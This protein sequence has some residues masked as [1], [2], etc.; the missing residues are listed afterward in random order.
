[1]RTRVEITEPDK[2]A[3]F[4]DDAYGSRLRLSRLD[5]PKCG[6]AVLSHIRL[7]AGAF[8]LDEIELLGSFTAAPDPLH[9]VA[10]VWAQRGRI[11]G[12]CGGVE[13]IARPGE[14]TLLAQPDLPFDAG[15]E[16]VALTTVLLDPAL[17]ASVATGM[18]PAQAPQQIRFSMFEPVDDPARRLWQHTVRYIRDSVL[19][20]DALASPL[21]LGH[22]ARMLAAATLAA[23]PNTVGAVET[24]HDRDAKPVLLQRAV[25]F[26]DEH[27][28]SD[29]ALG[30]IAAAIHVSPRAVQYMFRRHLD[31]TPL[32]YLRRLRLH[33]AHQ[34]LIAG[35]LRCDTVTAIA[36]R[37]GFGH[38]GRF[39]VAYRQTYGQS[40]HTTLRG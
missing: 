33:R 32:Q 7:D 13:G 36:A 12:R 21:V 6:G 8:V 22:A 28:D 34:D 38:T 39:A 18:P 30:D 24:A 1:M 4:L 20:D 23:F 2:A 3:A 5:E 27:L 26:I 15:G 25:D 17:M 10:A 35:D 37:W 31:S 9:R 14:V 11:A 19:A 29:I 40:P 16:N